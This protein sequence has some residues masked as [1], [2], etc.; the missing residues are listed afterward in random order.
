MRKVVRQY[1]PDVVHAHG[2]HRHLSTSVLAAARE[3]G[4]ATIQTCHDFN[5]ACSNALLLRGGVT[6]CQ[7][8]LCKPGHNFAAVRNRCVKGS[9]AASAIAAADLSL[10]QRRR[11]YERRLDAIIAPSKYLGD[12]LAEIHANV[13]IHVVPNAIPDGW[14]DSTDE[15]LADADARGSFCFVGRLSPEKGIGYL[16]EAARSAEVALDVVGDGPSRQALESKAPE[17]TKFRGWLEGPELKRVVADSLGVVVPSIA[18]ENAPLSVIEAM[19]MAKPVI[20]SRVG[21]VPELLEEGVTGILVE[22]GDTEALAAA[23]RSLSDNG[24]L[25]EEM[26][27]RGRE[28]AISRFSPERHTA[29]LLKVYEGVLGK[30]TATA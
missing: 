23:L 1:R 20:A 12:S 21:G 6:P 5:H 13:D 26:G 22:P 30:G 7:P 8:A 16:L 24:T 4:A 3:G 27:R 25:A 9:R 11:L 2:I 17:K 18:V 10:H 15:A 29:S 14:V 19:W 28:R